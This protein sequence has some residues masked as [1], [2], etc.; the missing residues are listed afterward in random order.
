MI[1]C[2][3]KLSVD[4]DCR[5]VILSGAGRMFTAGESEYFSQKSLS[6][7][8]HMYVLKSTRITESAKTQ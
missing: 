1:A 5:V 4:P 8:L 3:E 2:F 6:I 7:E